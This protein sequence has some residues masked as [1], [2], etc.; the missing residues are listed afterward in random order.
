MQSKY[1]YLINVASQFASDFTGRTLSATTFTNKNLTYQPGYDYCRLILPEYP[2]NSVTSLNFD[3][4][5]I[6]G[7]STEITGYE[8]EADNG[9]IYCNPQTMTP[10]MSIP[11][12]YNDIQITYN[13]GYTLDSNVPFTLQQ[14]IIEYVKWADTRIGGQFIGQ[15]FTNYE[16]INTSFEIT[17][18]QNVINL[19]LPFKRVL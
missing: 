14:A 17:V 5:H 13:A 18:P 12:G 3:P 19:L 10:S 15:R 8:L 16:G 1:E 4:N 6:W 11:T 2:V 7:A 9:I